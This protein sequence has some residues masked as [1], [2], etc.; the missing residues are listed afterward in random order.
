MKTLRE[1]DSRYRIE[2]VG[3]GLGIWVI[4][5]IEKDTDHINKQP[6]DFSQAVKRPINIL[7]SLISVVSHGDDFTPVAYMQPFYKVNFSR[8]T[9][10][11]IVL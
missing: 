3:A 10:Q 11:R 1:N 5:K 9:R 8:L 2:P 7:V 6:T 4:T